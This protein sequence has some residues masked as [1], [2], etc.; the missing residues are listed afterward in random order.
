MSKQNNNSARASKCQQDPVP[1]KM[2]KFNPGLSQI[3][4]I[5]FKTFWSASARRK[6]KDGGKNPRYARTL[7][8]YSFDILFMSEDKQ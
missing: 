8:A 3:L 5:K 7:R 2:V 4:K 1:R 6:T